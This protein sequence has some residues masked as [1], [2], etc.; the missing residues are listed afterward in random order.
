MRFIVLKV[1]IKSCLLRFRELFL[2]ELMKRFFYPELC[3][4]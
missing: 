3:P 4:R 1:I 2:D